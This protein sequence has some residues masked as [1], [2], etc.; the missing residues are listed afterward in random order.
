M[1]SDLQV[2]ESKLLSNGT[3]LG[4]VGQIEKLLIIAS[5]NNQLIEEPY[6]TVEQSLEQVIEELTKLH[7]LGPNH[8]FSITKVADSSVAVKLLIEVKPVTQQEST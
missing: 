7:N 2:K 5:S 4:I 6:K 1:V 3:R 8:T